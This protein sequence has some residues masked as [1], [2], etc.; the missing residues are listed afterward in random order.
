MDFRCP[1]L[2]VTCGKAKGIL[3]KKKMR[4]GEACGLLLF[5]SYHGGVRGRRGPL[6]VVVPEMAAGKQ[7]F[8][9]EI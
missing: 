1:K 3:Y 7:V 2:P 6:H 9:E 5:A 8:G 4:Q